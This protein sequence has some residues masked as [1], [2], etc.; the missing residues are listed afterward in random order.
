[1]IAK[2]VMKTMVATMVVLAV[3][4]ILATF[5]FAGGG[6]IASASDLS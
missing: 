4:F 5:C 1:M 2:A 3:V 6:W